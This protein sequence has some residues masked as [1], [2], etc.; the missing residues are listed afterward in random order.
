MLDGGGGTGRVSS[1][2]SEWID[3]LVIC[4]LSFPMLK[5]AQQKGNLYPIQ[6]HIERLPFHD[7]S[8][9]RILIVDAM[10]HFSNQQQAIGDLLRVLKPGGRLVIEEP[11][12]NRFVVKLIAL[13]EKIA[14]MRS[15]FY[16]PTEIRDMTI[17][18][19]VSARIEYDRGFSAWIIVDR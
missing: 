9:D 15:K 3:G 8:F 7:E 17:S 1:Q 16:T 10:H 4:D 18:K 19:G 14:F 13:A 5:V 12:I 11:D 6:S 2:F